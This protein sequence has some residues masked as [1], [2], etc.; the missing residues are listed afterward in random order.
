MHDKKTII[1]NKIAAQDVK[2]IQDIERQAYPNP[3]SDRIMLDCI[4]AGYQCIKMMREEEPEK[5]IAYAFLMIGVEESHLLNITVDPQLQRQGLAK[6]MMHRLF[7]ISRIN[8][9]KQMILEVRA[10]NEAA[11]GLYQKLG[12]KKIGNRRNYYQY[13]GTKEDAVVMSCA[14]HK[15]S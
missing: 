8:R 10:S 13:N 9:G 12:F 2:L 14:V 4:N 1:F 11:I 3:W 5:I 6:Q 15:N 7:L